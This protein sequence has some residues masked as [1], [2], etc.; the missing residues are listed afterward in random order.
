MCLALC[1]GGDGGMMKLNEIQLETWCNQLHTMATA[2][3]AFFCLSLFSSLFFFFL[4]NFL[5][6]YL[7]PCLFVSFFL[8]CISP[9][10]ENFTL[11]SMF[12]SHYLLSHLLSDVF[13]PSLAVTLLLF[14]LSSSITLKLSK[15]V[16]AWKLL[17]FFKKHS[18][19]FDSTQFKSIVQTLLNL[20]EYYFQ[21][22]EEKKKTTL[23]PQSTTTERFA[24][25]S[26]SRWMTAH[27]LTGDTWQTLGLHCRKV[28]QG[29]LFIGLYISSSPLHPHSPAE[30]RG[31]LSLTESS[32]L[33]KLLHLISS[34]SLL[35]LP[36]SL[37]SHIL[38]G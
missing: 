26:P 1:S 19:T 27:C 18:L 36:F 3:R 31:S 13:T 22:L 23:I 4:Y 2:M 32:S 34:L 17:F 24:L 14:S 7:C 10:S 30:M 37:L 9:S 35:L 28:K 33:T 5:S 11:L 20:E 29:S 16:C 15:N 6:S 38:P 8:I 25:H 12:L 21:K